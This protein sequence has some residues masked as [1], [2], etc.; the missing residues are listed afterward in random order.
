MWFANRAGLWA[1]HSMNDEYVRAHLHA[2]QSLPRMIAQRYER[3]SVGVHNQCALIFV[4]ATVPI[5]T[6]DGWARSWAEINPRHGR[7]RPQLNQRAKEWAFSHLKAGSSP[8]R[9]RRSSVVSPRPA[10]V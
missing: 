1:N 6:R 10:R 5:L 7:P 8:V 3:R 4:G 2:S 9:Q